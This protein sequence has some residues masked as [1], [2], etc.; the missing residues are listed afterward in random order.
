L[1][2]NFLE[3]DIHAKIL[4]QV[5]E[6]LVIDVIKSVHTICLFGKLEKNI[7][8][9]FRNPRYLKGFVRGFVEKVDEVKRYQ[10]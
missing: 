1:T 2:D 8:L 5:V 9:H 4:N 3:K 6:M 10:V 7:N